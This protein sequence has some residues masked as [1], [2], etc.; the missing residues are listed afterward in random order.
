MELVFTS[1]SDVLHFVQER[2]N[3]SFNQLQA[4]LNPPLG[5]GR[6]PSKATKDRLVGEVNAL[7]VLFD[8]LLRA[9]FK[10]EN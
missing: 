7:N 10:G 4:V 9:E 8:Q 1:Y 6:K 5:S 3:R 2:R